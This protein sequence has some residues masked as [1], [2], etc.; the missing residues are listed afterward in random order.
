MKWDRLDFM[1]PHAELTWREGSW[2]FQRTVHTSLNNEG[3]RGRDVLRDP[4]GVN[5][6]FVGDS[7]TFG[8]GVEDGVEYPAV[9][10]GLLAR[11]FP[12]SSLQVINGSAPGYTIMT[13]ANL[14]KDAL[15]RL[16]PRL[17][18]LTFCVNDIFEILRQ[19]DPQ[20]YDIYERE[21]FSPLFL[22]SATVRALYFHYFLY[23]YVHGSHSPKINGLHPLQ[24]DTP[25]VLA[26]WHEYFEHLGQLAASLAKKD[27]AFGV[28]VY[29]DL[30]QIVTGLETPEAYFNAFERK[31]GV[32]IL[33]LL[34]DFKRRR[35]EGA[36]ILVPDG[37]PNALGHRIIAESI[38]DWLTD[39]TE[40]SPPFPGV[41][42]PS[43]LQ[44]RK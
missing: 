29:P 3:F 6:L 34:N 13:E 12:E 20:G 22:T 11:R 42:P 8:E 27:V 18:L 16:S 36:P 33:P 25:D 1:D 35:H 17:V 40:G 4:E 41:L 24:A 28:I 31:S 26:A 39:G 2:I 10:E 32:P 30:S 15:P 5:L 21:R 9:V 38:V 43:G 23:L 19:R 7:V 14:V 44:N 37:H